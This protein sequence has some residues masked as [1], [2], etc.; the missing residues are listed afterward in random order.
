MQ[1][2]VNAKGGGDRGVK[3][4]DQDHDNVLPIVASTVFVNLPCL[5]EQAL[6]DGV[7]QDT[8][9]FDN[10]NKIVGIAAPIGMCD[11]DASAI[12]CLDRRRIGSGM[13]A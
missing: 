5:I 6:G 10:R 7:G 12:S 1:W 4:V 11:A 3:H 2:Q 8:E 13:Q 9:G